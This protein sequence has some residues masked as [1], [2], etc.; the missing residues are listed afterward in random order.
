MKKAPPAGGALFAALSPAN[1]V[2]RSPGLYCVLVVVVVPPEEFCCTVVLVLGPL[3]EGIGAPGVTVVVVWPFGVG[4]VVTVVLEPEG[5]GATGFVVVVVLLLAELPSGLIV[6]LVVLCCDCCASA[7]GAVVSPI[8]SASAKARPR[9]PDR[10]A[11]IS[12]SCQ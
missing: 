2:R 9:A 12:T 1:A 5:G 8:A 7:K 10:V 4:C 11:F 6:V 3:A